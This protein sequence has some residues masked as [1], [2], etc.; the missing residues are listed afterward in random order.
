M[1]YDVIFIHSHPVVTDVGW[2]SWLNNKVAYN[3]DTQ[4]SNQKVS[5]LFHLRDELSTHIGVSDLLFGSLWFYMLM[6]NQISVLTCDQCH[7]L[8]PQISSKSDGEKIVV[9]NIARVMQCRPTSLIEL[10]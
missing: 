3:R 6:G 9:E 5:L 7:E 8:C 1:L 2:T 4:R 10:E